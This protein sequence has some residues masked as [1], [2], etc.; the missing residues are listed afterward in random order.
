ML[1]K[2]FGIILQQIYGRSFAKKL[3][4]GTRKMEN[5]FPSKENENFLR[6]HC[7]PFQYATL[8]IIWDHLNKLCHECGHKI[9]HLAWKPWIFTHDSSFL[10][11]IFKNNCHIT[12][13]LFYL[14]TL[15]HIMSQ[16]DGFPFFQICFEFFMPISKCG[17]N[18][19]Y[20]RS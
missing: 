15:S 7:L 8:C 3:I 10:R 11:A 18:G 5:D 17:P 4:L 20:D 16:C 1:E 9:D 2:W 13:L 14:V 6:Q 19:G 12:R